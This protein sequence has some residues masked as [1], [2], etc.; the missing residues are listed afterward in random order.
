MSR[1]EHQDI[2]HIAGKYPKGRSGCSSLHVGETGVENWSEKQ[3]YGFCG[4]EMAK[5][6]DVVDFG[7]IINE[8]YDSAAA[9]TKFPV[10]SI[11]KL[12]ILMLMKI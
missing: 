3:S 12:F 11:W 10:P 5:I 2:V 8:V 4:S 6:A 9:V 1:K 7:L